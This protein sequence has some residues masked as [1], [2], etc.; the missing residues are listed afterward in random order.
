MSRSTS[1]SREA[2]HGPQLVVD[3]VRK[4]FDER[5]TEA[6][7]GVSITCGTGEFVSLL[8]PSGCG[9]TT[10]LRIIAGLETESEG[11]IYIGGR[12]VNGVDPSERNLALIFQSYALWPHMKVF[13]NIAYGLRVRSTSR[14]AVEESVREIAE[15]LE[16]GGLLHRF[17]HQLSGGQQQRVALARGLV[18]AS[19]LFLLD[20]PLSNL[21]EAVRVRARK[22]IRD[23]QKRFGIATVY[24]TH[25]QAEALSMSDRIFVMD[26]GAVVQEGTP[27]D[28]YRHPRN[29][30][31]ASFIGA[32]SFLRARVTGED[33]AHV[34]TRTEDGPEIRVRR[35]EFE[36][37][38][39]T[40]PRHDLEVTLMVRP[41]DVVLVHGADRAGTPLNVWDAR[42]ASVAYVGDAYDV[43]VVVGRTTLAIQVPK[44]VTSS[45][46]DAVR[47]GVS[48]DDITIVSDAARAE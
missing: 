2:E 20:E 1:D 22:V 24:V 18:Y 30:F 17:P 43:E 4:T 40:G 16:I 14:T 25:N 31:V 3:R 47:V 9:K 44:G 10:L 33:G 34:T 26:K 45:V 42:V 13:D 12:R 41:E 48:S 19:K 28:I 37:A 29:T 7:A 23:V 36:R 38:L 32:A 27:S 39:G 8:G 35:A 11:D 15:I 6:L 21:D 46:G 5:G